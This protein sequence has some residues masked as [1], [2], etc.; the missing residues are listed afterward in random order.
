MEALPE[1]ILTELQDLIPASDLDNVCR[2]IHRG[3]ICR[4]CYPLHISPLQGGMSARVFSIVGRENSWVLRIIPRRKNKREFHREVFFSQLMSHLKA[5][6]DLFYADEKEGIIIMQQ[7]PNL[8]PEAGVS[9]RYSDN[10]L[11]RL[12]ALINRLYKTEFFPHKGLEIS[13]TDRLRGIIDRLPRPLP[14]ASDKICRELWSLQSLMKPFRC[15]SLVHH[16]LNPNNV[17][18]D[19]NRLWLID[20]ELTGYGDLWYDLANALIFFTDT[21]EQEMLFL[22]SCLGRAVPEY[23]MHMIFLNKILCLSFYGHALQI[24]AGG[25]HFSEFDKRLCS[26]PRLRESFQKGQRWAPFDRGPEAIS[27]FGM[28]LLREAT[29]LMESARYPR[30]VSKLSQQLHG[31]KPF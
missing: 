22:P 20:W 17:L 25:S 12:A 24:V 1:N 15:Y 16:D 21:P 3:L 2:S 18:D 5:G 4:G 10:F 31:P 29:E 11:I 26:L 6:P 19:G 28:I 7:L 13:M 23:G 8:P 14:V 9:G 30:I 27:K